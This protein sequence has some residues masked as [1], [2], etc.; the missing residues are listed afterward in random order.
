MGSVLVG[1]WWDTGGDPVRHRLRTDTGRGVG[2]VV[3]TEKLGV[4]VSHRTES[5]DPLN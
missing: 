5:N 4:S 2:N 3:A 1:N